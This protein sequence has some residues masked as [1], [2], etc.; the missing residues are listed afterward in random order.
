MLRLNQRE[1]V[2]SA[3]KQCCG[4]ERDLQALSLASQPEEGW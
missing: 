4:L 2:S 1:Q 3:N